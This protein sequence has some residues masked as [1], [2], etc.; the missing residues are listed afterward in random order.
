MSISSQDKAQAFRQQVERKIQGLLEEFSAGKLNR[1]QFNVLY[2]RYSGQLQ[3]A[4]Q[5][6]MSGN[7]AALDRASGE[8]STIA[9]KQAHMGKAVGLVIYQNRTGMSI[10]TLGDFDVS[11]F[12]IS[13]ILND[14]S[15]MMETQ[16][17]IEH[18]VEAL[19]G[20]RWLLFVGGRF[21]TVV[22]LFHNEPSPMQINEIRRLHNDF[23]IAN[24]GLLEKGQLDSKQMA[25]P[26]MVF[27]QKKL[28]RT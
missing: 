26:F 21:T 12:V 25:Y 15:L 10:E 8:S 2:E 9:I 22:T 20:K 24:H 1:E 19:D 4:Q 7:A 17:V 23:E 28:K 27:V 16:R 6:L 5:A 3:L 14:F 18:R 13:P 11:A